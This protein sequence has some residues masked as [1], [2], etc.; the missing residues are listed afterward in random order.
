MEGRKIV[1][2]TVQWQYN[3]IT[4]SSQ[5]HTTQMIADSQVL[6]RDEIFLSPSDSKILLQ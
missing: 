6:K 2:F 3:P 1:I 5:Q 4:C